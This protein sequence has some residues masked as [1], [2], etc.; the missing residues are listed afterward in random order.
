MNPCTLSLCAP[1]VACTFTCC[2]VSMCSLT[3]F[4]MCFSVCSQEVLGHQHASVSEA[5]L[6][7]TGTQLHS[8]CARTATGAERER[9][10]EREG[11]RD[12]RVLLWLW[13][14]LVSHL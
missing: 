5:T 12:V 7:P 13:R 4:C 9:D 10:R 3:V 14:Q 11:E 8:F 2:D 6:W 1:P